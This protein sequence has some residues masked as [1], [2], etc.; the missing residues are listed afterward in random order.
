MSSPFTWSPN[1][2]SSLSTWSCQLT[3]ALICKKPIDLGSSE[4]AEESSFLCKPEIFPSGPLKSAWVPLLLR[5]LQTTAYRSQLTPRLHSQPQSS[6]RALGNWT[7][8]LMSCSCIFL[9]EH[10]YCLLAL[11]LH[12][13]GRGGGHCLNPPAQSYCLSV[14]FHIITFRLIFEPFLWALLCQSMYSLHIISRF[15]D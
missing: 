2:G 12:G 1:E 5:C 7:T 8:S 6:Y 4:M 11:D 15:Q 14:S 9:S 13:D 3:G 10:S